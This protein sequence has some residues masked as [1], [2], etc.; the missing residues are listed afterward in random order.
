MTVKFHLHL[1]KTLFKHLT[2]KATKE[3]NNWRKY[4]EISKNL[5]YSLCLFHQDFKPDHII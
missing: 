3:T 5:K 2:L 1:K 4:Q